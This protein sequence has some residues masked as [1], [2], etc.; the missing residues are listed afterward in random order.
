MV[1]AV[2][3]RRMWQWG[4]LLLRA[5]QAV[6]T[7]L[8]RSHGPACAPEAGQRSALPAAPPARL[9]DERGVRLLRAVR[10]SVPV[11]ATTTA[12]CL[13][14]WRRVLRLTACSTQRCAPAA[15]VVLL[16]DRI[17]RSASGV[18]GVEARDRLLPHTAAVR[19]C[20]AARVV[21]STG[22]WLARTHRCDAG[23]VGSY[24]ATA[25]GSLRRVVRL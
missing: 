2:C 16:Q 23:A 13:W 3:L 6:H 7:T 12:W 9:Q 1:T 25:G 21:A 5:V 8:A 17:C 19:R 11:H 15:L 20:S 22:T 24:Q 14:P 18:Q 10:L 4:R